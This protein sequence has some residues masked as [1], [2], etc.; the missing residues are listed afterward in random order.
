MID[1]RNLWA[2]LALIC[3]AVLSGCQ[4]TGGAKADSEITGKSSTGDREV[5]KRAQQRWSLLVDKKAEK[6]Y[7]YLTPGYRKSMSREDYASLK[8]NVA[9]TWKAVKVN[10]STCEQD[11]C[12]VLLTIDYD[13][14]MPGGAGGR[15]TTFAP[16]REKWVRLGGEWYFLPNK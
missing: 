2:V 11:T 15:M 12:E 1:I 8:N 16:L 7:D 4:S 6:A 10:S 5:E 13:V 3:I 14:A 9:M